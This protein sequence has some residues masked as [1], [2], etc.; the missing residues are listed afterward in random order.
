MC[1]P[2]K[3]HDIACQHVGWQ[4]AQHFWEHP[5]SHL[6]DDLVGK[7][8]KVLCHYQKFTQTIY[9]HIFILLP[10]SSLLSSSLPF[11]SLFFL[12]PS[13]SPSL[14]KRKWFSFLQQLLTANS[15]QLGKTIFT[16][17]MTSVA[18]P[19]SVHQQQLISVCCSGH[20]SPPLLGRCLIQL[21]SISSRS[22]QIPLS[23]C[24]VLHS[25]D[26]AFQKVHFPLNM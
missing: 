24:S 14:P 26:D 12:P 10:S 22:K 23:S 17:V 5:M 19:S 4:T 7:M 9:I 20:L 21:P 16:L 25:A 18:N 2:L 6:F 13:L 3:Y 11:P 8:E 15:S 1:W